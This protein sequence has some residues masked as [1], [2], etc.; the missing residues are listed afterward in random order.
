MKENITDLNEVKK[1]F[2]KIDKYKIY[3]NPCNRKKDY[4]YN[5]FISSKDFYNF[6]VGNTI[7]SSNNHDWFDSFINIFELRYKLDYFIKNKE[8]LIS[9]DVASLICSYYIA[10]DNKKS[11]FLKIIINILR[12]YKIDDH[13]NKLKIKKSFILRNYKDDY[14]VEKEDDNDS[15]KDSVM[16]EKN[17]MDDNKKYEIMKQFHIISKCQVYFSVYN[18]QNDNYYTNSFIFANEFYNILILNKVPL[19]DFRYW[20]NHFINKFELKEKL[21]YFITKSD[22]VLISFD[23]I[24]LIS[25]S[26]ITNNISEEFFKLVIGIFKGYKVD[27][28]HGICKFNDK[29]FIL[30]DRDDKYLTEIIDDNNKKFNILDH[31]NRDTAIIHENLSTLKSSIND[32]KDNDEKN[33]ILDLES[34]IEKLENVDFSGIYKDKFYYSI[35][36]YCKDFLN[37]SFNN[38][39]FIKLGKMATE[40]SRRYKYYIH[41]QKIEDREYD[42]VNTYHIFILYEVIKDYFENKYE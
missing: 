23:V 38:S 20:L 27:R 2:N 28:F 19:D 25:A 31:S 30:K 17:V 8:Y 4:Y 40:L 24:N 41:R 42:T 29:K 39:E 32:I 7:F 6:L 5:L 3:F 21:D 26:Y 12:C 33:K 1:E 18:I 14:V 11:N 15:I 10:E 36:D 13:Y 16:K 35:E 34:R 22:H 9:F 37:Y